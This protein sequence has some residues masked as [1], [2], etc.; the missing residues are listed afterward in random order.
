MKKKI[1]IS[2][3][4]IKKKMKMELSKYRLTQDFGLMD[5]IIFLDPSF[6]L[7]SNFMLKANFA[8]K[9]DRLHGSKHQTKTTTN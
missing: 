1:Q 4:F 2:K 6:S 8:F 9:E 5:I 7:V 3:L